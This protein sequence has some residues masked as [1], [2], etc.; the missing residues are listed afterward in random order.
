MTVIGAFQLVKR[1]SKEYGTYYVLNELF[2]TNAKPRT[3]VV[4][5]ILSVIDKQPI[6]TEIV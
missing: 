6:L 2:M 3:F 4:P 1:E 5:E